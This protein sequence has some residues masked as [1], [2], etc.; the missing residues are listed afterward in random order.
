MHNTI[1]L[2][3]PC[4]NL[5]TND[6]YLVDLDKQSYY[7]ILQ[8]KNHSINA[9]P[10]RFFCKHLLCPKACKEC[11]QSGCQDTPT[12][13][14][15]GVGGAGNDIHCSC[16]SDYFYIIVS[17]ATTSLLHSRGSTAPPSLRAI[18]TKKHMR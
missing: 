18:S 1:L 12:R 17:M 8:Y 2:S 11:V 6:E 5:Q 4:K 7:L 3:L 16:R 14:D 10:E 13:S 15:V 9:K